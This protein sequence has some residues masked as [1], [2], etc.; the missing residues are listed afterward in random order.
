MVTITPDLFAWIVVGLLSFEVVR[1]A[2]A[3]LRSTRART[4]WFVFVTLD[5]S[6]AMRISGIGDL[7]YDLTGVD[8]VA[9]LTKHL[10]GIGAVAGLLRWV[11]TVVPGR[12]DGSEE[13]TYRR[14]IS[15]RPRRVLTWCVITVITVIF[16]LSHRRS[17]IGAEDADFIF[18]QAGHLWGSLHLLLFYA[19]LVFGM[20]CAALMCLSAADHPQSQGAFKRGMQ[21]LVI[22]CSFG[23]IYGLLRSGYLIAR[24]FDKPFLGGELLV[25]LGSNA[26]LITCV[27]LTIC[28][29]AAPIWERVEAR[30]EAHGAVNDLRPLWSA[31]THAAP[32]V[33]FEEDQQQRA[34]CVLIAPRFRRHIRR[35]AGTA[36]DFW[37][38]RDL[39]YRLHRRV[40][41]ILDASLTIQAYI[42][43]D[44]SDEIERVGR[45]LGLPDHVVT[46]YLLR[47][48]MHRMNTGEPPCDVSAHRAILQPEGDIASTVCKLLPIGTAMA[49]RLTMGRLER[50]LAAIA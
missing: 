27:L 34:R 3:A 33:L 15:N 35:L 23:A 9:T 25:D 21:A 45:E 30:M 12:M 18:Q 13:P 36:Y 48:A 17:G 43:I 28:G 10:I 39:D 41:Q 47:T 20:V 14:V 32:A 29:S 37:N 11:T 42:P 31:V 2:P 7:L 16:P 44:M 22:G 40:N 4:L 49:D 8:D 19:Y 50:R 5:I 1:R 24:L 6:M 38:W 46:A 26:S